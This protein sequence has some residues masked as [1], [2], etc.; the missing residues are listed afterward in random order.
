MERMFVTSQ[1]TGES[2]LD[3]DIT[4]T[5]YTHTQSYPSVIYSGTTEHNTTT[6]FS[7]YYYRNQTSFPSSTKNSTSSK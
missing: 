7:K 3:R 5:Q 4:F 2:T 6:K 1:T